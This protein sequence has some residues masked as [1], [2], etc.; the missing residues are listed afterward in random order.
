MTESVLVQGKVPLISLHRE[1]NAVTELQCNGLLEVVKAFHSVEQASEEI[2]RCKT[3]ALADV[4]AVLNNAVV[5][6]AAGG[7][8]ALQHKRDKYNEAKER[9]GHEFGTAFALFESKLFRMTV[10]CAKM[11][12]LG[13]DIQKDIAAWEFTRCSFI[14]LPKDKAD[15]EV[16]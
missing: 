7:N 15:P 5:G 16:L 1:I 14:K 4:N 3:L 9:V 8:K 2:A 11:E 6:L 13:G 12:K 10:A